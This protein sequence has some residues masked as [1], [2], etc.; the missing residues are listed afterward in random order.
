MNWNKLADKVSGGLSSL[1]SLQFTPI[2]IGLIWGGAFP[3]L[4]Q[5]FSVSVHSLLVSQHQGLDKAITALLKRC[6]V[7]H[8][9]FEHDEK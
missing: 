2:N 9:G 8:A 4:A 1:F 5:C 3:H 6:S 7:G